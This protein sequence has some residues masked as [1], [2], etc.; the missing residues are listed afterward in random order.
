MVIVAAG[1]AIAVLRIQ[2]LDQGNNATFLFG[3]NATLL[4][5]AYK[6]QQY[7]IHYVKYAFRQQISLG[8]SHLGRIRSMLR[9]DAKARSDSKQ[10]FRIGKRVTSMISRG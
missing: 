3:T 4:F 5:G 6:L 10:E 9:R 8:D 1:V 7:K 2:E